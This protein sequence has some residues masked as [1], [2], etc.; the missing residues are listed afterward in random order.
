MPWT[1]LKI[2]GA[3]GGGGG[4]G[5]GLGRDGSSPRSRQRTT[6]PPPGE[7]RRRDVSVR[8]GPPR[9]F[10]QHALHDGPQG[11]ETEP[12]REEEIRHAPLPPPEAAAE[13]P[14]A[15]E[16]ARPAASDSERAEG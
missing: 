3:V 10:E 9:E 5:G 2:S 14:E 8:Q 6:S 7:T 16:G 12:R 1:G 13:A 4:E 15:D 11:E